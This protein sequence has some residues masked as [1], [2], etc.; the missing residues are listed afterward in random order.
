MEVSEA[1]EKRLQNIS[2]APYLIMQCLAKNQKK[3]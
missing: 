1:I 2:H 3:G